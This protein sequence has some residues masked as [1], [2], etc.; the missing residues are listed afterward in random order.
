MAKR[1]YE[2]YRDYVFPSLLEKAH[3]LVEQQKQKLKQ[4]KK[5]AGFKVG[6][7]MATLRK[8]EKELESNRAALQTAKTEL[9]RTIIRAPIPGLVV[10][11]EAY[12]GGDKRKPQIGDVVE[13]NQHIKHD[14]QD[15]NKRG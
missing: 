5:S 8:A 10:L 3:L 13:Q 1:Q 6:K 7:A 14:R 4:T 15:Q 2:T 9:G 12:R 11:R